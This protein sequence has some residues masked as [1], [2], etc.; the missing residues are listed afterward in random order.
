MIQAESLPVTFRETLRLQ[1]TTHP[2][3]T[4]ANLEL[5]TALVR[6]VLKFST[7]EAESSLVADSIERSNSVISS[8]GIKLRPKRDIGVAL[9]VTTRVLRATIDEHAMYATDE[10]RQPAVTDQLLGMLERYLLPQS[11]DKTK[12]QSSLYSKTY[13]TRRTVSYNMQ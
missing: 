13:V 1:A 2:K 10:L 3:L 4:L 11:R 8:R 6:G 5:R 12:A 7:S 9:E